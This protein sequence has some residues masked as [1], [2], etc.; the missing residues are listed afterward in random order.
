MKGRESAMEGRSREIDYGKAI[1]VILVVFTH[2][3]FSDY[4]GRG[5]F[6]MPVFFFVSGYLYSAGKH[7]FRDYAKKRFN[8]IL[9]PFWIFMGIYAVVE[10]FRSQY[11]GYGDWKVIFPAF[12]NGV[13][14]SGILPSLGLLGS[15]PTDYMSY[16]PQAEGV[17]DIIL[18]TDCHLWFL[19]AIFVA[20]IIFFFIAEKLMKRGPV[21]LVLFI[22][23]LLTLAGVETIP[24]MFQLPYGIGRGCFGA[25]LMTVGYGAC[26]AGLLTEK[27]PNRLIPTIGIALVFLILSHVFQSTGTAFVSSIYG[28]YPFI[29]VYI[30]FIGGVG[31]T[32]L[33][34]ELMR[35]LDLIPLE[36]VKCFLSLVGRKKDSRY[37]SLAIRSHIHYGLCVYRN[38][39][40]RTGSGCIL[41]GYGTYR[42]RFLQNGT[43]CIRCGIVNRN[44]KFSTK[45]K[46]E[47][48]LIRRW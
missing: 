10:I 48:S 35:L 15:L 34:L 26:R 31:G 1:A 2:I 41:Y 24:G 32:V 33:I 20:N 11:F 28:P 18:P 36:P 21:V 14:G 47:D 9:I 23:A 19:P 38:D 37:L 25:A 13:Y 29:S 45:D 4:L 3:G 5:L 8:R 46:E 16:K 42:S 17:I 22:F 27:K 12:V 43:A 30:T 40:Y 44:T 6:E 39:T 7:S